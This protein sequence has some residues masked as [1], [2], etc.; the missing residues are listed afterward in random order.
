MQGIINDV[1]YDFIKQYDSD[2]EYHFVGEVAYHLLR[3]DKAYE[4]AKS[5]REAL[6]FVFDWLV[7]KSTV[8]REKDRE[9]RG[10]CAA[11]QR[12]PL[13]YDIDK[14]QST[15]VTPQA[16]FYCSYRQQTEPPHLPD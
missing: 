9:R 2:S 11:D 15:E 10:S 4:G 12:A 7:K 1:F 16:F 3:D 14:A 5:H 8:N 6:L 13:A